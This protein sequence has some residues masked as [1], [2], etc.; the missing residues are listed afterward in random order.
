MDN[1]DDT[2]ES[3]YSVYLE[4]RVKDRVPTIVMYD[5]RKKAKGGL[6]HSQDGDPSLPE[7]LPPSR[8]PDMGPVGGT[9]K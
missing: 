5:K 8:C 7:D 9:G 1:R 4:N 2:P 6:G 3:M